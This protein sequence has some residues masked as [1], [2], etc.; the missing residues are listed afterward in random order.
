VVKELFE[1]NTA[2]EHLLPYLVSSAYRLFS[3]RDSTIIGIAEL[4]YES[5]CKDVP[6]ERLY[7]VYKLLSYNK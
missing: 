4:M 6:P 3:V 7:G 1:V 5:P 2:V